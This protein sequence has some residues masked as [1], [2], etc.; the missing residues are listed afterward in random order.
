MARKSPLSD[1]QWSEIEKRYFAGEKARRLADEF[2]ITEAAIRK[3]FGTQAKKIK[4]VANQVIAAEEAFKSLPYS[5]QVSAQN[6]IDDL[7][8]ISTHLAGAAKYGA[9]TAHRLNGIANMQLDKIDDSELSDPDSASVHVV[10]TVA[11]LTDV[12]NRAAQTGLNLLNANK[13]QI[14]KANEESIA[15]KSSSMDDKTKAA[16]L[17]GIIA[18]AKKRA[19]EANA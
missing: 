16:K 6:L 2:G 4:E 3:R 9:I 8:A 14:A 12:A 11:A 18:M 13:D 1:K 15:S 17:A 10:K 7:R 19:E 5:S